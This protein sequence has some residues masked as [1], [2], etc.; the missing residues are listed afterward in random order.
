MF[1][2]K[3]DDLTK[4]FDRDNISEG[5]SAETIVKWGKLEGLQEALSTSFKE[6]R[7]DTAEVQ[8]ARIQSYGDNMPIVKPSKSLLSMIIENFEDDMLR[9]LCAAAVVSLILGIAT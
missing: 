8:A 3:A 6:G 1:K 4:L 5:K 9:V 2:I 7:N